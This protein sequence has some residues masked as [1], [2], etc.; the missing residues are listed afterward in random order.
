M[1]D[2][3]VEALGR[4]LVHLFEQRQIE[5][6]SRRE[7]FKTKALLRAVRHHAVHELT[8]SHGDLARDVVSVEGLVVDDGR[9]GEDHVAQ[10][11]CEID[12][13]PAV[14]DGRRTG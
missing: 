6:V 9:L 4:T 12:E 11:R 1:V 8:A 13:V 7:A 10:G 14:P 2:D 3:E 5:G